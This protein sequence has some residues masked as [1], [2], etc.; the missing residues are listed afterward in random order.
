VQEPVAELAFNGPLARLCLGALKAPLGSLPRRASRILPLWQYRPEGSL[1]QRA[2][3]R[4]LTR[5]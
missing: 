4:I 5:C 1:G 3:D 2:P